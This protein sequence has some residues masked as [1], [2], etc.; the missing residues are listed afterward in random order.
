ML[1]PS[2]LTQ[3][4]LPA[5]TYIES[6]VA[7]RKEFKATPDLKLPPN[8]RDLQID[9]TS[10][11]FSIP[12]KVNFRYRLDNYDRDWHEAGT[13]RQAFYTDLPPGK[14]SFRVIAANSDG[15][16][17]DSAA[18]MDFFVAPAYWQTNWFRA[19]CAIAFLGLVWA[20]YQR[21][22]RQ[23]HH[24]FEMTLDARVS[25]RTRI[26]RD[27][28]DTLLQSFQGVLP[29]FQAAIYKLPEHPTD[30]R[31]TL[32][33][34]VDQASQAITEG[35]DAVQGL[36]ASTVEKN[37][38]AMAIRGVAE[39]LASVDTHQSSPAFRVAVQGIPRNLHPILRDEVYRIAAEALRNA[40][41]HAQAHQVE[42][43]LRYDEKDFRLR[44]RDDG[45][46]I[47]REVLSGD[48][49]EGHFGLHGMRERAKLAGGE[50]AI[51]SEVDSGTE[52]ELSIPASR[53]Y[54]KPVRRFWFFEKISKK[55]TDA[56]EKVES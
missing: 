13:R 22:V 25:E 43:E 42:V 47:H 51:W 9:Y 20:T 48:G 29:R 37:D 23:L 32:E 30:A 19:L 45:R 7:D 5:P 35:R 53:A 28:H 56:K 33:A 36:R 54:T 2:R 24:Q 41:R 8:P 40:F 52:V 44:I 21:R 11:T 12:Q 14:Y 31:E 15:V 26:A 3:K 18:K 27:L 38:L 1:D 16:W 6:L 17:N 55:D 50:L 39:E 46:G 4:A 10:P 49:R 34:A